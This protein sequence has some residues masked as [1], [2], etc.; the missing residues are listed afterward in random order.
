MKSVFRAARGGVARRVLMRR[1][2]GSLDLVALRHVPESLSMPFRRV[3][4]D[5]VAELGQTRDTAPV[6]KLKRMFG[7]TIWLVS[8]Y[9]EAKA[10]LA[11]SATFSNDVSPLL[12]LKP[13]TPAEAIGGLGMTDP[14]GHTQLRKLL[15]PE[16]TKHRMSRLEPR[17][18]EIVEGRLA[19][20]ERLGPIVDLVSTFAFPVPFLVICELLGLP[21]EEQERFR[22][23]GAAR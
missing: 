9:D 16:F 22:E 19:E 15:A 10:V 12:G 2:G 11:D 5:P 6:K 8:G 20:M 13:T 4:V 21:A 7:T 23:L 3:G 18:V 14:P 17:I 1:T